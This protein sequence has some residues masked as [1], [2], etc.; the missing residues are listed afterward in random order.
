MHIRTA[1]R[2]Q[3]RGTSTV[4]FKSCANILPLLLLLNDTAALI[5]VRGIKRGR[6]FRQADARIGERLTDSMDDQSK[7]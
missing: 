2:S 5:H 6:S 4:P 3:G 7:R 1:T